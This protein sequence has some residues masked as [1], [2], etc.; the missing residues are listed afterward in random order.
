MIHSCKLPGQILP[1]AGQPSSALLS[2][3]TRRPFLSTLVKTME[4]R[5][6]NP[7]IR[8]SQARFIRFALPVWIFIFLLAPIGLTQDK[9]EKSSPAYL[10]ASL[11]VA[12]R[13][14]DLVSRMT[15]EEKVR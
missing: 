11:P 9:A 5:S 8:S 3:L 13:V 2:K 7:R 1:F 4:V 6:M 12:K 10:N 14:D 15:L